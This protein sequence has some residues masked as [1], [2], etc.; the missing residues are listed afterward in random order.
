MLYASFPMSAGLEIEE[1][2]DGLLI[3]SV[4]NGSVP[5]ALL[6]AAVSGAIV[7]FFGRIYFHRPA[8]WVLTV[9][10]A[11]WGSSRWWRLV[12]V[13][14]RVNRFGL[15]VTGNVK[16]L[17]RLNRWMPIEEIRRLEYRPSRGEGE[18]KQPSGLYVQHRWKA[19]CILPSG[20]EDQIQ[21]ILEAIH[22]RFPNIPTSPVQNL[23]PGGR[24][25]VALD[26]NGKLT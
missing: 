5:Y 16:S 19:Y 6:S 9:L 15:Q 7:F 25:P 12:R 3:R 1:V 13:E 26:L 23:D 22:H 17:S 11:I 8:L 18:V 24:N 10:A 4:R 21:K 20:D 14:L 2:S